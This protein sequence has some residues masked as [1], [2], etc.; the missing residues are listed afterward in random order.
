MAISS[1]I[2]RLS[3]YFRR[4][5]FGATVR[6]AAVAG[7]RALF[8]NRMVL[9]YCD[10]AGH[11]SPAADLPN[12][13]TVERHRTQRDVSRSDLEKISTFWNQRL[14]ER[15]IE[16]RFE[17][18]ASLW[19]I[20]S[21]GD[22]AGYG[23]T[24]RGRTVEPHYLP[25]GPEDVHLFDFQVFPQ[26]R[27]RGFNPLLVSHILRNLVLESQGRAFIEAAEWNQPQL[28]SL[29]NTPVPPPGISQ[30]ISAQWAHYRLLVRE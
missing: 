21:E 22:L 5:G 14:S 15:N 30:Q 3:S 19:L 9:L 25:L 28:A 27:G 12:S 2:S 4:H 20:K 1:S 8:S 29:R 10:L 17:L 6:R 23:W 13:L 11:S 18:G 16:R 26:Y 7:R 24:L